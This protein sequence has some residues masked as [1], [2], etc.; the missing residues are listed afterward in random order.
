MKAANPAHSFTLRD[1]SAKRSGKNITVIGTCLATDSPVKLTDIGEITNTPE[2]IVA[3]HAG[4]AA[5]HR[6]LEVRAA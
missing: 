1:W 2:G 5:T 6:L 4:G 3:Q